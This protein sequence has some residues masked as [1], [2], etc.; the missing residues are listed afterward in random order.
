MAAVAPLPHQRI[1]MKK[2]ILLLLLSVATGL[3]AQDTDAVITLKNGTVITG[4]ITKLNPTEGLTV[5]VAGFATDISMS[6][7][8]KIENKAAAPTAA[9]AAAEL[10]RDDKLKV[11]DTSELPDSFVIN[12]GDNPVTMIL[13]RGGMMNMGYDG[14]NSRALKS[15]PVH[16][17]NVTSFYMSS[18]A[19][20]NDI[21]GFLFDKTIKDKK[22]G[23]P[24]QVWQHD[25]AEDFIEKVQGVLGSEY[26]LPTEAEW[27]YAAFSPVQDKLFVDSGYEYC[28]EHYG[29]YSTEE[30]TDPVGAK[31]GKYH[32]IR[33][34]S[35]SYTKHNR[36]NFTFSR[37]TMPV[38][39]MGMRIVIKAKDCKFK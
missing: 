16:R 36:S 35:D 37:G 32:V 33:H 15:E 20:S 11:T 27:E 2:I 23:K 1:S 30:Q 34:Y 10:S 24:Y 28:N 6:D 21:Y 38:V 31:S 9:A 3:H 14:P 12:I 18:K 17:V 29:D 39:T 26:R 4:K 7:V 19:L 13:V 25:T 5:V 8:E 22:K